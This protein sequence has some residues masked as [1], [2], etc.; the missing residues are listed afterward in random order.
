MTEQRANQCGQAEIGPEGARATGRAEYRAPHAATRLLPALAAFLVVAF[1][2]GGTWAMEILG[3]STSPLSEL[4]LW[5]VGFLVI[6]GP[7]GLH[8][9]L[10]RR[11][12][13]SLILDEEGVERRAA[14]G[15]AVR[16]AWKEVTS[17]RWSGFVSKGLAL[18]DRRAG[19]RIRVDTN[20]EAFNEIAERLVVMTVN[21]HRDDLARL[22]PPSRFRRS[23]A[24]WIPVWAVSLG[25]GVPLALTVPYGWIVP[26]VLTLTLLTTQLS[27]MG[28]A[29][30]EDGWLLERRGL[31]WRRT[32]LNAVERV[33][34]SPPRHLRSGKRIYVDLPA[35]K[36]RMSTRER[37]VAYATSD[38]LAIWAAVELGRRRATGRAGTPPSAPRW[39]LAGGV[40][41]CAGVVALFSVFGIR[42][43]AFVQTA[44]FFGMEGGVGL[45]LEMGADPNSSGLFYDP[46]LYIAVRNGAP[47]LVDVLLDR[48][49]DP[50]V[51]EP[52]SGLTPLHRAARD[53]NAQVAQMLL[54]AG[55]DP[56]AT[57]WRGSTPLSQAAARGHARVVALLLADGSDPT[58][59]VEGKSLI[60]AAMAGG[61]EVVLD[62]LRETGMN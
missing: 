30:V 11:S 43:G 60:E 45:A 17:L 21:A 34:L 5:G 29:I 23:P 48:G 22:D 49:G 39:A 42:S 28:Q 62:V 20:F 8:R 13:A 57:T 18:S 61:H 14:D 56:D 27:T 4:A 33:D 58:V 38:I 40:V 54:D 53:G 50:G 19:R 3:D 6:F 37:N 15:R 24:Q 9:I 7:V 10:Q 52:D 25:V 1:T 51:R 44:V 46:P 32:R 16:I 31:R 47:E 55:A 41:A 35:V 12:T 26:A 59:T 36:L 2:L